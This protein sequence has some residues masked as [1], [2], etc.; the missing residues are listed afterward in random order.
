MFLLACAPIARSEDENL[1]EKV[2]AKLQELP[3]AER[4]K[5]VEKYRDAGKK[6]VDKQP[7][8]VLPA[9]L[10][11][12]K[13]KAVDGRTV[14]PR[15]PA[16]THEPL[17]PETLSQLYEEAVGKTGK[18]VSDAVFIRR[19]YLDLV[20][21]VPAP[22]DVIEYSE[23]KSRNR[24]EKLVDQLL[25]LPQYGQHWGK[26]WSDVVRYRA[27]NQQLNRLSA[28]GEVDWLAE[29]LND[30]RPWSEIVTDI[31]TARGLDDEV[32]AGFFIACHDGNAAELAG[33]A[34][35][36]FLGTQIACAQC[37]DHPYDPWKRDQFHELAAFFGRT[38]FRV[39]RD[40][41]EEKGR[42]LVLEV[43]ASPKP[44]TQYRKPDLKDP[45]KP[46]DVVQP[47][48]LTGQPI[49]LQTSDEQRREAIAA[50]ATSDKNSMFAKA[51]VNRMWYEL[52]GYGF[53]EP[54]DDLS[55]K[56]APMHEPLFNALADSFIAS[57]YDIKGLVR[58]I[59]LSTA[60]DRTIAKGEAA[61]EEDSR[62][63]R[64]LSAPQIYANLEWVLGQIDQGGAA[65][66]NRRIATGQARFEQVFGFDPSMPPDEIEASVSQALLLMNSKTLEGRLDAQKPGTLLN[67]ILA[68]QSTDDGVVD[69]LYLR[70]LGRHATR[71]D[72]AVCT[73]H[74]QSAPNRAEAAEDIL[75]ALINSTEFV[76][77]H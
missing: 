29:M 75:W 31:L 41:L 32:P 30:N 4:A 13:P 39:R 45:S 64:R 61:S 71:Q 74:L 49:P 56:R 10:D 70:V 24:K 72:L 26:Y 77:E 15:T 18:P 69:M 53:V 9:R 37:H 67:K 58:T 33:E 76:H 8:A 40:L 22:A 48:F 62:V 35:R 51:F 68:T 14:L 11:S 28:Y 46:G 21:R 12:I 57:N 1:K 3:P 7:T 66:N 73:E 16:A 50:F 65:F 44:N 6:A 25:S 23:D 27:T 52:V 34:S 63:P 43:S 5:L 55:P 20:G 47:V 42:P 54:I 17:T 38:T 59:V 60:Y 2:R 19:V 36:I